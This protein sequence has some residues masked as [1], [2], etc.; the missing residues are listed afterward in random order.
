M[1]NCLVMVYL[2][3]QVFKVE[4]LCLLFDRLFGIKMMFDVFFLI[5]FYCDEV[6]LGDMVLVNLMLFVCMVILIYLVMDNFFLDIFFFFVF[7]CLLWV[8]WIKLLGERDNLDDLID[9]FVLIWMS[10]VIMGYGEQSLEDYLGLFMKVGGFKYM[11]LYYRVYR[12]IYNEWFR[13]QN[14]IDSLIIDLLDGLD[15]GIQLLQYR[16]KWY[17]YFISVLL[18]FQKGDFVDLLFGMYVFVI[19]DVV[20]GG[21]GKIIMMY[22]DLQ[23]VGMVGFGNVLFDNFFLMVGD[24]LWLDLGFVMDFLMVMVVMINQFRQVFQVQCLFECDVCGGICYIEIILV[25]FGVMLF[26]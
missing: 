22:G 23:L 14:F 8:N 2:F 16:V 21:D 24:V 11:V 25:Y 20:V 10:L 3:V 17:D 5:L 12:L 18:W 26:D 15:I 7:Y 19:L 13:D 6:L 1:C 4:I 9:Y